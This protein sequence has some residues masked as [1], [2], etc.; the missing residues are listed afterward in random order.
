M[1]LGGLVQATERNKGYATQRLDGVQERVVLARYREGLAE[2][3][4][5]INVCVYTCMY[6]HPLTYM[7]SHVYVGSISLPSSFRTPPHAPKPL[8]Y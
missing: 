2:A 3:F 1:C 6:S 5:L 8:S 4:H 7:L